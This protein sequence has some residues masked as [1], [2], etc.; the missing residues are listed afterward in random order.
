M[1]RLQSMRTRYIGIITLRVYVPFN[2]YYNNI[3][4]ALLTCVYYGVLSNRVTR[5]SDRARNRPIDRRLENVCGLYLQARSVCHGGDFGS[6]LLWY[7]GTVF[8]T[9]N[10]STKARKIAYSHF[11]KKPKYETILV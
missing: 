8:S 1:R 9:Q 3:A 10:A 6:L 4:V 7:S 5:C 11:Y 2:K